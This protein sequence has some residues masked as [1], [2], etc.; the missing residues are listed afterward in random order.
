MSFTLN[1]SRFVEY[2]AGQ[3][4][5]SLE[6][7]LSLV[8]SSVTFPA[9]IDTGSTD[10]IFARKYGEQLGLIIEDGDR[11]KIGTATGGFNVYRHFVTLGVL[12]FEFD[13]AVYFIEDENINRSVLGRHGFLDRVKFGLIDYEGKLFLSSYNEEI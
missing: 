1:F 8:N 4:G 7:K 11:I 6:I 2:D 3:P 12:N 10:C 5:V 9:K 13:V